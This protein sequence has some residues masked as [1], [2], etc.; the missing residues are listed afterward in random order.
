VSLPVDT[1]GLREAADDL[2]GQSPETSCSRRAR[3]KRKPSDSTSRVDH[4]DLAVRVAA[5]PQGDDV[6]S[7]GT[8]LAADWIINRYIDKDAREGVTTKDLMNAGVLEQITADKTEADAL[9]VFD[10][11]LKTGKKEAFRR[12][13]FNVGPYAFMLAVNRNSGLALY[14]GKDLGVAGYHKV[15]DAI[16]ADVRA[17]MPE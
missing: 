7:V 6:L 11:T 13:F 10:S 17:R 8:E 16:A 12:A 1:A 14:S 15:V 9:Y 5:R 2:Y 3:Y 4:A